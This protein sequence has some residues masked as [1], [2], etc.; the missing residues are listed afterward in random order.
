LQPW[1]AFVVGSLFGWKRADGTRRF[2]TAYVEVARKN[3]KSS[4]LTGASQG[5]INPQKPIALTPLNA[6]KPLIARCRHERFG[7]SSEA[8]ERRRDLTPG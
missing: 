8:M 7:A 4:L 3:G 2:R 1:Q 6:L 5:V